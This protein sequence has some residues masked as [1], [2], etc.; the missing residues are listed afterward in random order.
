MLETATQQEKPSART[1]RVWNFNPGPATLPQEVLEQAREGLLDYNGTGMGV[2]ELSHRSKPYEEIHYG[3]MNSIRGPQELVRRVE[4]RGDGIAFAL[5]PVSMEQLMAVADA[6][7]V[8]PPK[9]TWF[10]PKLRSGLAVH[11]F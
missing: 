5:H 1:H 11:E 6:G 4:K 8:L 2:M 7:R 3:L 9:S 10:E